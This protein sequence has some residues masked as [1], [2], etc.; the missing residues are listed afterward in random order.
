MT[1]T[2]VMSQHVITPLFPLKDGTVSPDSSSGDRKELLVDQARQAAG[3]M[4]FKSASI[5]YRGINS[6]MLA[7]YITSV[8]KPGLCGIH[9]LMKKIIAPENG[10]APS[11]VKYDDMPIAALPLDSSYSAQMVLVNITELVQS[12]AFYGIALR[13]IRDLSARFSSKEGFPPPAILVYRDTLNP[14][15]QPKW[16]SADDVPDTSVGKAGDFYVRALQGI[17]YRKSSGAWDSVASLTI[18]PEQP[19]APALKKSIRRPLRKKTY[20]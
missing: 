4:V 5:H 14:Y 20:R 16:W 12:S 6:A 15:V 8:Q 10:V 11:D 19:A 17:I 2:A 9:A 7:V 1:E 3:W 13:P 18:P